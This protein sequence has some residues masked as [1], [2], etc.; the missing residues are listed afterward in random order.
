MELGVVTT[1]QNVGFPCSFF[2]L[3]LSVFHGKGDEVDTGAGGVK[4][5]Y[6]PTATPQR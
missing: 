5:G 3:S 6:D 1:R 4:R 2:V